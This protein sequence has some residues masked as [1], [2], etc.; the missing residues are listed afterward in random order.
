MIKFSLSL[1]TAIGEYGVFA[2]IGHV[3][4]WP[5]FVLQSSLRTLESLICAFVFLIGFNNL[6]SNNVNPEIRL[7]EQQRSQRLAVS[8]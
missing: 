4:S 2:D 6:K 3:K 5:W 7:A 8:S 1:Y